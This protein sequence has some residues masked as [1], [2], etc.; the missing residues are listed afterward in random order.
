MCLPC[1]QN[2]GMFSAW[3]RWS[4]T[5]AVIKSLGICLCVHLYVSYFKHKTG[6][7]KLCVCELQPFYHN[8]EQ[9]CSMFIKIYSP[10][11][12]IFIITNHI[13]TAM[14]AHCNS[15]TKKEKKCDVSTKI[16][17]CL[18]LKFKV[19]NVMAIRNA[20][21]CRR[22]ATHNEWMCWLD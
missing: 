16:R 10:T 20:K 7:I 19:S 2:H 11:M 18:V 17:L 5:L 13:K 6:C 15:T 9:F 21:L 12:L 4:F 22:S 14:M 1:A 3:M 8:F